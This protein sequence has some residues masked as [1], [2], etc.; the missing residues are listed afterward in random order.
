VLLALLC[1]VLFLRDAL[2]PGRALVP[3]PPE[4][5]DVVMAEAVANGRFDAADTFRGNV[6]MTDKYLQSLCWDRVLQDR[7]R[8]GE[9]PRWTN[10]IGGGA[11]FVPQMAQPWQPINLLLLALPSEQWYGWWFLLH[12]VLF[13]WFAYVFLRR[14]GCAHGPALL[15]LCAAVLGLWTQCK[16]HH[17]VILT[18]ALSLWPML[19]ATHELVAIGA[20]GRARLAAVGWLGLWTGL[21]WSTGFVVVSLQVTYFTLALALLWTLQAERG[22]RL[23]RLWPVACGLGLG[24]L[25]SCANMLPILL[26]KAASA[27]GTFTAA[28]QAE[29][30]LDWDHA[31]ALLWPDLLSWP[32]DRF[33]PAA[34]VATS[35]AYAT[36]MPWSQLVLVHSPLRPS[37][38]S[39]LHSYVETAIAIGVLPLLGAGLALGRRQHRALVLGLAALAVA[40]FGIA[41]ADQ[42]FLGLAQVVPG[43]NAGDLRRQLFT[44]VMALVVLGTLG[45]DGQLRS[46][47][48]LPLGLLAGAVAAG[49]A[50]ALWWLWQHADPTAFTRGVAGLLAADADHAQV[51]A[52]GGSADAL[53]QGM[54]QVALPG[55]ADHNRTMLL[56][57]ALRTLLVAGFGVAALALRAPWRTAVWIALTIAELLHAGRGP[58]QTVPAERVTRLPA[59]LQPVADAAPANG[60]RP[61]L[62]RLLAADSLPVSAF[63]GNL[64]GFLR[65][66]DATAYNPLPPRRYEEFFAAIDASCVYGGAGVGGFRAA[67]AI[68]H[69]LADLYGI[70][71]VLTKVALPPS[72]TRVE[73]TP[74]GSGAFRLYERTTALPRATFVQHV[75]VI[76]DATARLAA[77]AARDREVAHRVVLEDDRAPAVDASKPANA[78]VTLVE[79][80]DEHVVVRVR[81]DAAGYLRLADPW[82]AGWCASLDGSAVPIHQADHYLRAV[83]VPAGEHT[84]VFTHDGARVVWPLRLTLLATG[85]VAWLLWQGRRRA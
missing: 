26:A 59:V 23:R 5:F 70:R 39:A 54:Q 67:A 80:R 77:L 50:V 45:I 41:T 15:G 73:R 36:R 42:P 83:H 75:D 1:A 69:P 56:L 81:T 48:R 8:N 4:L 7:F 55:E 3:H 64:P 43:L 72:S 34:E 58:V 18:A 19:S 33:Y 46:G 79:R 63:P 37:D 66:E 25:W 76:A 47:R 44:V 68:D 40:S 60:D 21:S 20:R 49:S 30:G 65:L 52:A 71:F 2:L 53:A 31:L 9:L 6:G 10:D 62:G 22:D 24:G 14:L 85:I 78:T 17:N 12:Q 27:R 11:P 28:S 16:L 61:R 35:F 38:G 82:D 74:P 13:G 84:I 32:A 57:T 51:Q 29:L